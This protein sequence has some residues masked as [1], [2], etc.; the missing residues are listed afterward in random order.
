MRLSGQSF[1]AWSVR[2]IEGIE[3]I[4]CTFQGQMPT[5]EQPGDWN[6]IR[7]CRASGARQQNVVLWGTAIEN[8]ALD[9]LR[10]AGPSPMFL[11]AC[12]M[13]QVTLRG[14]IGAI[15]ATTSY[16]V[17]RSDP[18]VQQRWTDAIVAY[19]RGVDWALD[20]SE[21]RFS[22]GM[23]FATVPGDLVR[24]DPRRQVLVRR[25]SLADRR[26]IASP[27]RIALE[28]FE[29]K[30]PFDSVVL[31]GRDEPRHRQADLDALQQL[32]DLGVAELD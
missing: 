29:K 20:I 9:G 32:R 31:V 30:S 15:K 3:A 18:R 28:W 1:K 4:D 2:R 24:R 21:A 16:A 7:D 12:V 22:A 8:C 10:R 26:W 6:L 17:F 5:P 27:R 19:Y 25:L 23:T 13:R 14:M 11:N